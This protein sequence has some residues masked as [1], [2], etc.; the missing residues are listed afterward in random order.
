M[1]YQKCQKKVKQPE[2]YKE[3]TSFDDLIGVELLDEFLK[4]VLYVL[5]VIQI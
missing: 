1:L 3:Y 5:K 2:G 4:L